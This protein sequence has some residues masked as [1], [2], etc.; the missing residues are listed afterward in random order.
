MKNVTLKVEG[1]NS[2]SKLTS[3][4]TSAHPAA[5]SQL[6]LPVPKAM[7]RC[8]AEKRSKL[9]SISTSRARKANQPER[10][11]AETIIDYL[12]LE[13]LLKREHIADLLSAV[14]Y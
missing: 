11:D 7:L 2:P 3:T 5:A 13:H 9:A 14:G 6:R 12:S 1:K 10:A 8:L 4:R